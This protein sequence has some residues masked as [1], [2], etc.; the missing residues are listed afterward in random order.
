MAIQ[1]DKSE[2]EVYVQGK[3]GFKYMHYIVFIRRK[4]SVTTISQDNQKCFALID[5]IKKNWS[6]TLIHTKMLNKKGW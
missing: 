4:V 5:C 1:E 3:I 6:A 2:I